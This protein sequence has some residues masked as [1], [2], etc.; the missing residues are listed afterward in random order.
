MPGAQVLNLKKGQGVFYNN[1]ISESPASLREES[2][3]SSIW[4]P[5]SP[6]HHLPATTTYVPPPPPPTHP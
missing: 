4:P 6:R 2:V 3:G 5:Q 1:N